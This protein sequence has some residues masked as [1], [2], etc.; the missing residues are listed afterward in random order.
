MSFSE[1]CFHHPHQPQHNFSVYYL[2]LFSSIIVRKTEALDVYRVKYVFSGQIRK[3]SI[4][5]LRR[6]V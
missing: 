3:N 4:V 2:P 6:C 1:I 5:A